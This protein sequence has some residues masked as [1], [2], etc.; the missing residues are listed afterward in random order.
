MGLEVMKHRAAIIGAELGVESK[1]GKGVTIT[2]VL[3][4]AAGAVE[5][6]R[7]NANKRES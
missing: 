3:P 1:S 6:P 7:M 2:C 4:L 5:E